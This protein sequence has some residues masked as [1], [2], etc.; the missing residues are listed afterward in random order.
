MSHI[1]HVTAMHSAMIR[2]ATDH[3]CAFVDLN[4]IDMQFAFVDLNVIFYTLK[5]RLKMQTIT[6]IPA[7]IVR[8]YTKHTPV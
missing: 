5:N 6:K 2:D 4:V 8:T 3:R 7:R 1:V